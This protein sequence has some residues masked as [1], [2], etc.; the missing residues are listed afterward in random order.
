[1]FGTL[2]EIRIISPTHK[3]RF[4]R[5]F[6]NSIA[7]ARIECIIEAESSFVIHDDEEVLAFNYVSHGILARVGFEI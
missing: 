2:R 5:Y 7:D 1:M 4:F 3:P 6:Q